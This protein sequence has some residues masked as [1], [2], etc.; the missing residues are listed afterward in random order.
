MATKRKPGAKKGGIQRSPKQKA[1]ELAIALRRVEACKL[2]LEGHT[3]REIAEKLGISPGTA[4]AD[5]DA[6]LL[7]AREDAV[8]YVERE[9]A[10]SIARL[11]RAVKAIF[12]KVDKGDLDAVR[13]LAGIEAQRGKTIGFH[14]ADKIEHTGAAGAPIAVDAR[15]SLLERLAGLVAGESAGATAQGD[16]GPADPSGSGSA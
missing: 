14:A 12:P 10:I 9:K 4:H 1:K 6:I 2:R 15:S 3:Q 11:E 5:L 8:A 16:S 13:A 7:G